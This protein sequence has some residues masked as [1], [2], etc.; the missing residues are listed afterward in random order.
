MS[1]AVSNYD[2][3][4][5]IGKEIFLRFDQEALIRKYRLEADDRWI[6]LRY[7]NA[8]CRISRAEGSIW[9]FIDDQWRE[10]RSFGTVMTVYDLLCHH[11]GEVSPNVGGT[12]KY[13]THTLVP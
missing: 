5:D 2:L 4:V 7:L 10:C 11:K 6:F 9:E 13:A 1:K 8:P 12:T 3:Q